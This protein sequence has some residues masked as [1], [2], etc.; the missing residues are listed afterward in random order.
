[1]HPNAPGARERRGLWCRSTLPAAVLPDHG[2]GSARVSAYDR[3]GCASRQAWP[4]EGADLGRHRGP[5][6]RSGST[7]A[8]QAAAT[9][10][11]GPARPRARAP[12]ARVG[13]RHPP[14]RPTRA[15]AQP[16]A[17]ARTLPRPLAATSGSAMNV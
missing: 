10:A 13:D 11:L 3:F 7:R 2:V 17:R 15:R 5:S 16:R 14:R 8:L 6:R 1:L 4:I 12:P 9:L